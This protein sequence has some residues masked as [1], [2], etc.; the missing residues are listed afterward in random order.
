MMIIRHNY[1]LFLLLFALF[2]NGF[3]PGQVV[4]RE[5][6]GYKPNLDDHSFFGITQTRDII[7]LNGKWKVYPADGDGEKKVTINI[8]SVFDGEG[9]FV[10]ERSFKI[11]ERNVKA[12]SFDLVFLGLNYRADISI[13]NVIIYRHPGGEFPFTID[14]P[15]DILK[16]DTANLLSVKLFYK[17]DSKITI[18]LKQRFLFT[19]NYGG[20]VHDVYIYKKPSINIS[21]FEIHS[22]VNPFT[23]KAIVKLNSVVVDHEIL[24]SYE[25]TDVVVNLSLKAFITSPDSINTF[26]VSQ[27]SF[28]L[29]RNKE[30]AIDQSIEISNPVLWSPGNPKSYKVRMELWRE[31][32][33]VDV[34]ERT[35]ALYNFEV[36]DKS[37]MLNGK[38]F[39]L[40]GVTYIPQFHSYG[41]LMNYEKFDEDIRLIKNTGFN[42]VRIA[43]ILPHPYYLALCEKYGLIV[44]I[45]IPIGML[46]EKISQ[47]QNFVERCRYFIS[48]YFSAYEK[49]SAVVAVGLG[50][51][52]LTSID[53]HRSLL[54]N[55]GELVKKNTDWIT[56]ATFGNLKISAVD[57]IDLYGL[58]LLNE[59]PEDRLSEINQL[60]NDIGVARIFISEATYTVNKGNSDGYVNKFTY[61]AQAKFCSDLIDYSRSNSLSGFFINSITDIR[62]DYSSLLSGYTSN[63]IYNIGLVGEDRTTNRLAYKVVYSKLN[64]TERVTIPIGSIKDDAP[65]VFILIGLVLALFMGV[66]VNSGRKFREDASR[67]LLRPYNYYS[68]IR[69]Q[70]IMSAYHT[71][72]LGVIIVIVHALILS[73]LL[74]YFKTSIVFEKLLLSFGSPLLIKVVNY[75]CWNPFNAIVWIS[76][77]GILFAL[78][79][80]LLIRLPSLFIKTRVYLTSIFFTVIWAFLPMVFLIPLGIVLYRVLIADI[81]NFYI[82]ISLIALIVWVVYRLL[83]GI[84]IIFDA[85]PGSVYFYSS[86]FILVIFG[87]I[88]TYFE[89]NNSAIQYILFTLKQYSI[90]G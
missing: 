70:R 89:I 68:D 56:F 60:Q 4:F 25:V 75:L 2:F 81:V 16:S 90:I 58:E 65:M 27:Y 61:E 62:G 28:G 43:K 59:L 34:L 15:R 82:Y 55:L 74:Y 77:F 88:L 7:L 85:S 37:L 66:L 63:N 23:K 79:T 6:P 19:R 80:T 35:V 36:T 33:L 76:M 64:N 42:A 84:Y 38:N 39:K 52:F 51:S 21:S 31:D 71:A 32:I 50:S 54:V 24:E 5:L 69:D 22:E 41:D 72:F 78:L 73:N 57:N 8:P 47:D 20:I 14:L 87:S 13:N 1:L 17:L 53:S 9:E 45:E 48:S 83:K 12:N 3:T 40:E 46:P 26:E 49:Y 18:P 44:F 11:S 10:F 29:K 30:V 86:L 67:A